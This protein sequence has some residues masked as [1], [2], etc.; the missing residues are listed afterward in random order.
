MPSVSLAGVTKFLK[1]TI[2]ILY[3]FRI[4]MIELFYLNALI[5]Y[6]MIIRFTCRWNCRMLTINLCQNLSMESP[7]HLREVVHYWL[8][9]C[10]GKKCL[11]R[12]EDKTLI[13]YLK[14]EPSHLFCAICHS[15]IFRA[16]DARIIQLHLAGSSSALRYLI[17]VGIDFTEYRYIL[18]EWGKTLICVRVT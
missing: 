11:E 8:W 14:Q 9:G 16:V 13:R 10:Q 2:E 4:E 15:P 3:Y 5:Q 6:Q 1:H 17:V 12:I 7:K 18:Y